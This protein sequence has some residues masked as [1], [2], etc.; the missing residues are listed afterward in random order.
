MPDNKYFLD[1]AAGELT[2]WARQELQGAIRLHEQGLFDD[3][4]RVYAMFL[5]VNPR[6]FN[7]LYLSGLLAYQ[8][9]N[10]DDA[11]RFFVRATFE[12]DGFFELYLWLGKT[13]LERFK[14]DDAVKSFDQAISL[15][16]DYDEAYFYKGTTL[17]QQRKHE[18]AGASFTQA[19]SLRPDYAEAY[20][21]R[22]TTLREQH[23]YGD[24]KADFL[25]AILLQPDLADAHSNF[26][27]VLQL[28]GKHA[29]SVPMYEKAIILK[30]DHV[31]AYSNLG[32]ALNAL[33]R[34]D[35]S[36]E[37]YARAISIKPDHLD[38][39]VNRGNLL[40][41]LKLFEQAIANYHEALNLKKDSPIVYN[42]LGH[43]LLLTGEFHH[44]FT[45]LEWRK[46]TNEPKGDRA[47]AKP[48]WLGGE[49]ISN[50]RILVHWEQG[51]GDVIQFSRYLRLLKDRGAEVLFAPQKPLRQ[52]MA[53][54][55]CDF[56]IVDETDPSIDFNFH[57][58]IMSLPLA[59]K[60]DL[61]NIPSRQSYLSAESRRVEKWRKHL[62]EDGF[63]VGVC[64]QGSTGKLD[65]G[66]S[67][68][69]SQFQKLSQI[70]GLRLISLH[71]G[72]GEEQLQDL[73]EGMR[74]ETL[75]PDFDC[76]PDAFLD[77]AAV[78][79]CCDLVI[80]SDTAVAHLAGALGVT[81]WVA[82]KHVPDWRW[83]LDRDDS[84]WYPTLRLFRQQSDG[85]WDGVFGSMGA[86]L[87]KQMQD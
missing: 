22:G 71:K 87:A 56:Q 36:M 4:G 39:Y 29:E 61:S 37:A 64:W 46:K 19:I 59:L 41:S 83:L 16:H 58:P 11:E 75:G 47:F 66:R 33:K 69:L 60:T 82:L 81:T 21:N 74:V 79:T 28:E 5:E 26:G 6:Y 24:A 3:A 42:N 43:L 25:K 8:T 10:M 48:L 63:R 86:A 9:R 70:P 13:L 65:A 73:P 55:D 35:E 57:C 30:Q 49:D 78:M 50:R 15:K 80:T 68:S 54:L 14:F 17:L 1:S 27:S 44:G 72:A 20:V 67:F 84:P 12:T 85:D 51:L 31:E 62:G 52:L 53:T 45:F 38:A 76:G 77:T 40:L 7:V 2:V 32:V 18:D 34:F 23:R